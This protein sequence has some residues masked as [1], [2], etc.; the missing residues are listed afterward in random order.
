[1]TDIEQ[2]EPVAAYTV[3]LTGCE[4]LSRDVANIERIAAAGSEGPTAVHHLYTGQQLAEVEARVAEKERLRFEGDLDKWMKTIGAGIT[5]YQPEAYAVLDIACDELVRLRSERYQLAYAITGGEDAPGLLD[6]LSASQLVEI[7]R[8]H[9]SSHSADIDR[10]TAAEARAEMAE[11]ELS[12][13]AGHLDCECD[14]DSILHVIREA[15]ADRNIYK[16]RATTAEAEAERLRALVEEALEV[17]RP[18]DM[19]AHVLDTAD[20]DI[21][22]SCVVLYAGN[23]PET[24]G[25]I[26]RAEYNEIDVCDRPDDEAAILGVSG[27]LHGVAATLMC[28]V[29]Q[30]KH[31]RA[32][33]AL[34]DRLGVEG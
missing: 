15:E 16:E 27:T 32:A 33:R 20:G 11:R 2:R 13:I 30:A 6:S 12:K 24:N 23:K 31:L 22:S 18:F 34:R 17:L 4:H 3:D 19:F 5:G 7:A 8:D 1:M 26:E 14:S 29:I 21:G 10:S 9:A 28:P 25:R